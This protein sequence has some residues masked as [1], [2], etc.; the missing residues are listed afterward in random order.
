LSR[1]ICLS[2]TD[3]LKTW[4]GLFKTVRAIIGEPVQPIIYH[5]HL[6]PMMSASRIPKKMTEQ[7][8]TSKRKMNTQ[9]TAAKLNF[10]ILY[11]SIHISN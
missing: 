7:S 10:V 4:I 2:C 8:L 6:A 9:K 5:Q 3:N 11:F 1:S